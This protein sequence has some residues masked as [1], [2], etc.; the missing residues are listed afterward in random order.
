VGKSIFRILGCGSSTGVPRVGNDWGQC[1][2]RNPK[3]RR[4]RTAL[5]ITKH[6]DNERFT[7]ILIDTGP[8]LREQLL[9]ACVDRLDAVL[10]THAHADHT[11]G[12]NDLRPIALKHKVRLDLYMDALTSSRIRKSFYYCFRAQVSPSNHVR[13]ALCFGDSV[14]SSDVTQ[15]AQDGSI[16]SL[17]MAQDDVDYA[18]IASDHVIKPGDRVTVDGPGGPITAVSFRQI[19]GT[20]TSLGFRFGKVAYATDVSQMS[21]ETMS[22]LRGLDVLIIGALRWT[23]HLSH[24]TVDQALQVIG[25]LNP[26][27]AILTHMHVDLDYNVLKDY[28]PDHVE[29]GY[30]DMEFTLDD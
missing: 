4:R 18:P 9:S 17:D 24:F 12:I 21:D 1:D 30:D 6:G 26:K 7:R 2:Q 23:P 20:D 28:L 25:H 19:H 15:V 29:P 10:Y 11:H 22:L 14:Q 16:S 13:E 5:L 8:D 27:R 3:N